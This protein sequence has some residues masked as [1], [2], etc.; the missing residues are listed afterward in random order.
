MKRLAMFSYDHNWLCEKDHAGAVP[1]E[2]VGD[3]EAIGNQVKIP[4]VS[5]RVVRLL[6][7]ALNQ[8]CHLDTWCG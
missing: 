2:E 3:R 7:M 6:L 5:Y 8:T 4:A 1:D